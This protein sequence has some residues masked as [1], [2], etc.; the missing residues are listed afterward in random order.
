M[1]EAVLDAFR[2]W[3]PQ[4]S[5]L[6]PAWRILASLAGR[7][8]YRLVLIFAGQFVVGIF[9]NITLIALLPLLQLLLDNETGQTS[10][11]SRAMSDVLDK[12]GVPI[13]LGGMLVFIVAIIAVK[14]AIKGVV[15]VYTGLSIQRQNQYLREELARRTIR[16]R[17]TY[18]LDQPAGR[19]A[20]IVGAEIQNYMAAAGAAVGLVS[21]GIQTAV[22]LATSLAVSWKLTLGGFGVGMALMALMLPILTIVRRASHQRTSLMNSISSRLVE[23]LQG[24]KAIKSMARE[25]HVVALLVAENARIYRVYRTMVVGGAIRAI[26]PEPLLVMALAGGLFVSISVL[27]VELPA[28]AI[29]AILF[30]RITNE[31]AFLNKFVHQ[32]AMNEGSV[33]VVDAALQETARNEEILHSGKK[34]TLRRAITLNGVDLAYGDKRV[35]TNVDLTIPAN[36]LTVIIGPSGSGKTSL[37]DII[38][39]FVDIQAG[40][41][42][43]DGVLLE[44]IDL[45]AWREM[46]GY[47]PQDLFLFNDTIRANITLGDSSLSE[48]DVKWA[49]KAAEAWDFV[50]ALPD[51]LDTKA[52]ERGMRLSG[53]QRQRLSIARALVR[54]PK[55]LMLDEA[56]S[57]L[58]PETER[59]ICQMVRRLS[60]NLTVLAVTH[61]H[62][63]L[64]I[65]DQAVEIVKGKANVIESENVR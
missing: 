32:I 30:M 27:N 17:W 21:R 5:I 59:E 58:D 57:A 50:Q 26:L 9:E 25:N 40:Q 28:L 53:G 3:L 4:R 41:V 23:T 29:L 62:A 12:L 64:S 48:R 56:T 1:I 18:L 63:F 47:V 38:V 14:A 39:G 15:T 61:Q 52:G 42:E 43:I 60:K 22:Y 46:I 51:G 55:L 65:A 13:T 8:P 49:L 20:N 45:K 33:A 10:A 31:L 54:R 11:I 44:D 16:A 24:I 34:P 19:L 37:L 6:R 35:L 7:K 36:K 2:R